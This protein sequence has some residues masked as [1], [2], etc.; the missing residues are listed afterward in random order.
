MIRMERL[1]RVRDI[2]VFVC[3]TGLAY[4]DVEQLTQDNIVIV[5]DGKKWIYTMREKTDGKSNIPL[6]PKALAILEKYR[7]YQRAK[8]NGKLLPVITNIKTNEY[9]KEI[10][11]I[12]GIK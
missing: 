9:L 7:D 1:E 12:C 10:A 4:V 2:F 6:L 8:K 3:Y 5:I 11:D